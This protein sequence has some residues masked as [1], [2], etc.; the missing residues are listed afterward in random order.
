MTSDA[1]NIVELTELPRAEA[2]VCP[3][4]SGLARPNRALADKLT[5]EHRVAHELLVRGVRQPSAKKWT[6]QEQLL[7]AIF[8][9]KA[10]EEPGGGQLPEVGARLLRHQNV[11]KHAQGRVVFSAA[12]EGE[13]ESVERDDAQLPDGFIERITVIVRFPGPLS[14][15]DELWSGAEKLGLVDAIVEDGVPEPRLYLAGGERTALVE[16]RLPTATQRM[17]ARATGAYDPVTHRPLR[18]E[19]L[20]D[21]QLA[22]LVSN[23]A[24]ALISDF[25]AYKTG[26]PVH[27]TRVSELLNRLEPIPDGWSVCHPAPAQ[28][29]AAPSVFSFFD[30]PGASLPERTRLLD[31]W[32]RAC[33]LAVT[34]E[35]HAL[36][37]SL[38]RPDDSAEWSHGEIVSGATLLDDNVTPEPGGL[39]C[40]KVFGPVEDFRCACGKYKLMKDRG[41]VCEECGVEVI[42]SSVRRE[43]LGHV[44]LATPILPALLRSIADARPWSMLPI[45]PPA[46]RPEGLNTLYARVFEHDNALRSALRDESDEQDDAQ[47]ALQASVDEVVEAAVMQLREAL[48]PSARWRTDY[49]ASAAVLI[50]DR[51]VDRC[52]VPLSLLTE[53]L[54]PILMGILEAHGYAT[55]IKR[56][57]DL[58]ARDETTRREMVRMA[59]FDRVLLFASPEPGEPT[60]AAMAVEIGDDPVIRVPRAL[61]ARLGLQTGDPISVHLPLSNAAQLEAKALG[62]LAAP[63]IADTPSWIRDVTRADDV[64]TRITELAAER[65]SDPCTWPPAAMLIGGYPFEGPPPP[66]IELGPPPATPDKAPPP[67]EL[68]QLVIDLE[69]TPRTSNLLQNAGIETLLDLVRRSDTELLRMKGFNRAS[70]KEVKNILE[71]MNLSLGMRV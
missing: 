51:L 33:G 40:Q 49:S 45:S 36:E 16:R 7:R 29:A 28:G 32:A 66:A 44:E 55:T 62:T 9:E 65:A 24:R 42:R 8:G 71:A 12:D 61:A 35:D 5:I 20:R 54:R 57:T 64:P 58:L 59:M 31:I 25:A 67:E 14:V 10:V 43:R 38:R 30:K 1:I 17:E 69:L 70:L 52:S 48:A 56:A 68:L 15:G 46:L 39:L 18:G 3:A 37:L 53:L 26:D 50:D 11:I 63:P 2:A 13:V 4:Q 47:S 19:V 23:G 41:M 6:P 22:W 27:R 21:E 34:L 60:C